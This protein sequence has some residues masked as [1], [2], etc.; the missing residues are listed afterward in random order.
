MMNSN[1][2]SKLGKLENVQ[3][4]DY[5]ENYFNELNKK[6]RDFEID[7]RKNK[8]QETYESEIRMYFHLMRGKK[9]VKN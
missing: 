6:N 3:I 2:A 5:I 9:K 7:G 4:R 8:T 1:A